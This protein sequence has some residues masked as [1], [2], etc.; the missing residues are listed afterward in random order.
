MKIKAG[1]LLLP[2]SMTL[3][4]CNQPNG[5]PV[6]PYANGVKHPWK[7]A[8]DNAPALKSGFLSDQQWV[9]AS[10][11]WGPVAKDASNGEQYEE[12]SSTRRP[13]TIGGKQYTK[14]IGTHAVSS[15]VYNLSAD[16]N[17]KTF[18]AVV[19]LDDEIRNQSQDGSVIFQ[20]WMDGK[21][22][23]NSQRLT[24]A[25]SPVSQAVNVPMNGTK[26]LELRVTDADDGLG[27]DH[28][29]WAD[30]QVECSVAPTPITNPPT[31]STKIQFEDFK[32]GG[33]GVAYHDNDPQNQGGLYRPNEGVD[34]DKRGDADGYE[35]GW[36]GPGEWMKYDLNVAA[37]SYDVNIRY[38]T[39]KAGEALDIF[40]DDTKVLT[41][42]FPNISSLDNHQV[43]KAGT[44]N[45]TAGAHVVKVA[46]VGGNPGINL[47]WME[48]APVGGATP[49][50]PAPPSPTPPPPAPP[51]PT[52]PPPAPTPPPS[53]TPDVPPSSRQI[54]VSP[55]GNDSASGTIDQPF[56]TV[57]RGLDAATP[58]TAVVLRGGNYSEPVTFNNSGTDGAWIT[59]QSQPGERAVLGN[60]SVPKFSSFMTMTDKQYILIRDVTITNISGELPLALTVGGASHHIQ[61][62]NNTVTGIYGS[63]APYYFSRGISV[64]NTRADTSAH[65]IIIANNEVSDMGN[66][67]GELIAVSGNVI[68][69]QVIGNQ[70]SKINLAI[71]IDILGNYDGIDGP[72]GF[73]R[74]ILVADNTLRDGSQK[75][76]N[77]FYS[78]CLYIDGGQRVTMERN[79]VFTCGYNAQILSENGP[80]TQ[81]DQGQYGVDNRDNIFRDNLLVN[82]LTSCLTVG[83]WASKYGSS[84]N[85]S[86][87]NNTLVSNGS[88]ITLNRSNG[89]RFANNIFVNQGGGF[90]GGVGGANNV[91][92]SHNIW[93]GGGS[94]PTSDVNSLYIDPLLDGSGFRPLSG[95]PAIDRGNS[96]VVSGG[97]RDLDGNPRISGGSVDIGAFE[98]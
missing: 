92:Y 71:G 54:Y 47:D 75:P 76:E 84:D 19:G 94:N 24:V 5:K 65:D 46:Y 87:T 14:G 70:V 81:D 55:S 36:A 78:I 33:E 32:Q 80:S 41:A 39:W 35:I 95:S 58:G 11:G 89:T 29:D 40:V 56:R 49:P 45:L 25:G 73:A 97:E 63:I 1:L 28:A 96:S 22:V 18:K 82:C 77:G 67:L 17:C 10:G 85:T 3:W 38:G 30:A 93:F 13:I 79:R 27:Y 48:F 31:S 21:Q 98:R 88:V 53:P 12:D 34:I 9:S 37:G 42:E 7:Q 68:N 6:N 64:G 8:Q 43:I 60:T 86:V 16:N 26:T 2:L 72:N 74:D 66:S 52:P 90:I 62:R 23:W 61:I 59:L 51:S 4:A 83:G 69:T 20:V 50:P 91:S 57:Q 44:V 15:I